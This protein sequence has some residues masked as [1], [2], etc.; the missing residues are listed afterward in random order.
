MKYL[1]RAVILLVLPLAAAAQSPAVVKK[2]AQTVA[3]ALLTGDYKTV[4]DHTY[5]KAVEIGGGKTKMLQMMTTGLSQMRSQ[6]FQ[7]EKIT[8]GTPG[9]FY[10]AG[11]EIHCLVPQTI[12]MKT[13][14]GRFSGNSN[15]LAV[16]GDNGKSWSFLDLNGGSIKAIDQIFPK[17]N[18]DLV[19]PEPQRAVKL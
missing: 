17:F 9:K 8:V 19:I 13:K 4:L 11:A 16:S 3:N 2:Q 10:K 7:F 18:H 12:V 15:L 1:L 6:G 5:P 14:Q